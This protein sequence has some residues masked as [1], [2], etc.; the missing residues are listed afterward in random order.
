M[1]LERKIVV[2]LDH[3]PAGR[4][5]LLWAV[6]EAERLQARITVLR[7]VDVEQRADLAL[8]KDLEAERLECHDRSQEWVTDTLS[9]HTHGPVAVVAA[10][11]ALEDILVKA[12]SDSLLLVVGEPQSPTLA[13][14]HDRLARRCACP[15]VRVDQDRQA[16]FVS[17]ARVRS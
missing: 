5:A 11:G 9:N 10:V 3:S 13:E 14:V 1:G 2:G 17:T 12:S 8:A 6:E 4:A 7:V 15:V 16:D